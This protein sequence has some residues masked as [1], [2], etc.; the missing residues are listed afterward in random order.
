[1]SRATFTVG[2][3]PRRQFRRLLQ[4]LGADYTEDKGWLDSQFILRDPSYATL[5]AVS[6]FEKIWNAD[7]PR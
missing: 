4:R 3:L 6:N 1:M 5:M 2:A 7:D